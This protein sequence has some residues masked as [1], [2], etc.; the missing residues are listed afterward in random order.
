MKDRKKYYFLIFCIIFCETL[1]CAAFM[2]QPNK[3][4]VNSWLQG[5]KDLKVFKTKR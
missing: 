1:D 4:E 3:I 5:C 2:S